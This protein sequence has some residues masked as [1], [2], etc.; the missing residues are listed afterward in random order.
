MAL[1]ASMKIRGLVGFIVVAMGACAPSRRYDQQ[2]FQ[3]EFVPSMAQH[4]SAAYVVKFANIADLEVLRRLTGG[5]S[6]WGALESLRRRMETATDYE[7]LRSEME[8]LG[9]ATMRGCPAGVVL[10]GIVPYSE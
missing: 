10:S 4:S 7:K 9:G 6:N 3:S 1:D 2:S 5:C 8:L